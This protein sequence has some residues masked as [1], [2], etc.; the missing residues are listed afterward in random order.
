MGLIQAQT[1]TRGTCLDICHIIGSSLAL[2]QLLSGALFSPRDGAENKL[3]GNGLAHDGGVDG[4]RISISHAHS[5]SLQQQGC[6]FY[7]LLGSSVQ[8]MSSDCSCTMQMS[9]HAA[10]V[11]SDWQR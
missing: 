6:S 1:Q 3:P 5:R 10:A 11:L 9:S 2:Q 7:P 4:D 8:D